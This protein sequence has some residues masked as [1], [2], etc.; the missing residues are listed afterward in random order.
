M[1]VRWA[2]PAL[3]ALVADAVAAEWGVR[4]TAADDATAPQSLPGFAASFAHARSEQIIRALAQRTNL[5]LPGARVLVVG[6]GVLA[7]TVAGALSRAGSRI[8]R[9]SASPIV[10]LR[11]RLLGRETRD[12]RYRDGRLS[13]DHVI[14]TGEGHPPLDPASIDGVLIDASS[15]GSGVVPS[16]GD[17]ARPH[18]R[19]TEGSG[20]LV[21]DAP[22]VFPADL[23]D[24]GPIDLHIVDLLVALSLLTRSLTDAE[25]D[26]ELARLVLA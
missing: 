16:T 18:V 8:V 19:R 12:L 25:A 20:A 7:E 24:A 4:I 14:A 26:A 5:V 15:D 3:P 13:A 10:L 2:F 11:S 1:T 21:V 6:D 23:A 17:M 9:A 22:P